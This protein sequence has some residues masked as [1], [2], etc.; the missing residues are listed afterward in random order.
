MINKKKNNTDGSS[1]DNNETSIINKVL[2][3]C[4]KL[5]M[6]FGKIFTLAHISH[7]TELFDNVKH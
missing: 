7:S 5:L 3:L 4:V 6:M 1:N 2:Y